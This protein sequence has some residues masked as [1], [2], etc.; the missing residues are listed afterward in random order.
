MAS[1]VEYKTVLIGIVIGLLVGAGAG[2]MFGQSPIAGY[3]QEIDRLEMENLGIREKKSQLLEEYT[4]LQV[5]LDDVREDLSSTKQSLQNLQNDY[6]SLQMEFDYI[7]EKLAK[8]EEDYEELNNSYVGLLDT[9][10]FLNAKNYS[11]T[12]NFNLTAGQAKSFTYD[13]GH[14]IIWEIDISFDGRKG[15]VSIFWR[16]GDRGGVITSGCD[17]LTE[18]LPYVSGTAKTKVYE[19]GD[20]INIITSVMVTEFPSMSRTGDGRFQIDWTPSSP[21]IDGVALLGEWP[22]FQE[23]DLEYWKTFNSKPWD[24]TDKT[25]RISTVNYLSHLYLCLKIPDD[26]VSE[27]FKIDSVQIYLDDGSGMLDSRFMIWDISREYRKNSWISDGYKI[28]GERGHDDWEMG[29]TKDGGGQYSHTRDG[30]P[31]EEGIYTVE[32]DLPL[33]AVTDDVYDADAKLGEPIYIEIYFV[34]VKEWTEEGTFYGS[35]YWKSKPFS[36]TFTTP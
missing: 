4:A 34:E 32:L 24:I 6:D 15:W 8:A 36:I 30:S 26:Y 5:Q 13:I 21:T 18:R 11:R 22:A 10:G 28:S 3:K 7:L 27:Y 33:R 23:L 16:R 17:T 20:I 19:D 12:N 25:I 14:G 1:N 35:S 2:Y 29:R 31:G 9:L